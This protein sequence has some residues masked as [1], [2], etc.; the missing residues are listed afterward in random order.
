MDKYT[1]YFQGNTI[2]EI[3]KF[4][5]PRILS[6]VVFDLKTRRLPS[7]RQDNFEE[8]QCVAGIPCQ[9]F[10]QHSFTTWDILLPMQEVA[11]L[12]GG[13]ITT[14]YFWLQLEYMRT[15]KIL[16][17]ICYVPVEITG[18]VLVWFGGFYG[19]STF[20]GY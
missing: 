2:L 3:S 6:F 15:R 14:K 1:H 17:T 20:V 11:K 7:L 18:H 16:V 4:L 8:L 13:N 5:E 12:A 9:Y 10:C 19:I